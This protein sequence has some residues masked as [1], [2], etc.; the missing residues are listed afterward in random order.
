MHVPVRPS[1]IPTHHRGPIMLVE[2]TQL[3]QDMRSADQAGRGG[4]VC[5]PVAGDRRYTV[6][7]VFDGATGTYVGYLREP[8]PADLWR[9]AAAAREA[10]RTIPTAPATGAA[11]ATAVR[12]SVTA[13]ATAEYVTGESAGALLAEGHVPGGV[14][15]MVEVAP[16]VSGSWWAYRQTGVADGIQ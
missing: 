6:T 12:R 14:R 1:W 8:L 3:G 10:K 5:Y 15:Q 11:T 4:G 13:T 7:T 9:L 16:W 2:V